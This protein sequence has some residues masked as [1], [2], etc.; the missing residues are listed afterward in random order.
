MVQYLVKLIC[1]VSHPLT[2]LITLDQTRIW[3]E[4]ASKW[5]D[6]VT[7]LQTSDHKLWPLLPEMTAAEPPALPQE[8]A[9]LSSVIQPPPHFTRPAVCQTE[10][11]LPRVRRWSNVRPHHDRWA[12]KA[13]ALKLTPLV[14]LGWWCLDRLRPPHAGFPAL[15]PPAAETVWGLWFLLQ[16]PRDPC[17]V[18]TL[19]PN[20]TLLVFFSMS[21]ICFHFL[22]FM[23][24]FK[25][26]KDIKPL[27][28]HRTQC[29]CTG[30]TSSYWIFVCQS[31]CLSVNPTILPSIHLFFCLPI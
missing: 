1:L 17:A 20:I 13:P 31:V 28:K 30:L 10:I 14:R 16:E 19:A 12:S 22:V 29:L 27:L 4:G 7:Y 24:K 26:V 15:S 3:T 18:L 9:C 25:T 11:Y 23:T 2:H 5:S 21:H 6:H 8:A